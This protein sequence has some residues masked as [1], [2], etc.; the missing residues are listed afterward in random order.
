MKKLVDAILFNLRYT[1]AMPQPQS[2]YEVVSAYCTWLGEPR[3]GFVLEDG[4]TFEAYLLRQCEEMGV[5]PS[6]GVSVAIDVQNK[7]V[8]SQA[9]IGKK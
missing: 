4:T 3:G 2:K 9:C 5:E 7:F 6:G 8:V 1:A